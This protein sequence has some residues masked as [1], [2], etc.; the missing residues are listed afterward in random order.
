MQTHGYYEDD[1]TDGQGDGHPTVRIKVKD[2]FFH[3]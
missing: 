3:R 2:K 1:Y